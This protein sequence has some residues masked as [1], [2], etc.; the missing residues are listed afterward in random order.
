MTLDDGASCRES[1][2]QLIVEE[3]EAKAIALINAHNRINELLAH[4]KENEILHDQVR[5]LVAELEELR[6][7]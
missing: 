6:K 4:E 5:L 2:Y 1:G 7:V 3:C